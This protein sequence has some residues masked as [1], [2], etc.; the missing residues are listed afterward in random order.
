MTKKDQTKAISS[1][2]CTKNNY[3]KN[4]KTKKE[5]RRNKK[6]ET[7]HQLITNSGRLLS[8]LLHLC[9]NILKLPFVNCQFFNCHYYSIMC[10]F[11]CLQSF[12]KVMRLT[13]NF[14]GK[15]HF[16]CIYGNSQFQASKLKSSLETKTT[17]R[18]G[19]QV[20][21]LVIMVLSLKYL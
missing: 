7:I 10:F 3:S 2:N 15:Q 11:L 6:Q 4:D 20:A 1:Y 9:R 8:N 21:I 17:P 19:N 18:T 16:F 14:T 12:T 5:K 13:R